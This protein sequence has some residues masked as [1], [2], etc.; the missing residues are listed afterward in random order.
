MVRRD[1]A[2][3][4]LNRWRHR[5]ANRTRDSHT[6]PDER[7]S[8]AYPHRQPARRTFITGAGLAS[9]LAAMSVVTDYPDWS[10]HVA[11]ADQIANTGA[12]LL[13]L[14]QAIGALATTSLPPGFL[15]IATN[16]KFN[17]VSYEVLVNVGAAAAA[18]VPFTEFI[19]EWLD[20][21]NTTVIARDTFVIP[22]I[23]TANSFAVRGRGPTKS[24]T[25]NITLNNLDPV[26]NST[27]SYQVFQHSRPFEFD[28]WISAND[29]NS[30]LTVPG[31]TLPSLPI[32]E[33][34]LGV[35]SGVT[36][37]TGS[38]LSWLFNAAPG[39]VITLS[40]NTA[41]ITPANVQLTALAQPNA[42]YG[43]G[44]VLLREQLTTAPFQFTIAGPRCPILLTVNNLA[45]SGTLTFSG[46]MVSGS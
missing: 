45:T 36:I 28:T 39:K 21:T 7:S 31:F 12:P 6:W 14:P 13:V 37:T 3:A 19:M 32:D 18:T 29:H 9:G 25:L 16:I 33:L 46:M 15:N 24:G 2:V 30:G 10:G 44:G 42:K 4:Y 34:V 17:Q 43:N 35:L 8:S 20:P 41:G 22:G 26:Q 23:T 40:G 38:S 11:L 27:I 1:S 5:R